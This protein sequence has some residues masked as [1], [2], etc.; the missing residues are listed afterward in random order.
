VAG[1]SARLADRR[2]HPIALGERVLL[3][4][5]HP[6]YLL[7]LPDP[8]AKDAETR[9]FANDLRQA[10]VLAHEGGQG[11]ESLSVSLSGN[12]YHGQVISEQRE[13]VVAGGRD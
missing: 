10:A 8:T 11:K 13:P 2:G 9:A 3:P 5:I 1:P 6:A 4:T 12:R 7:R